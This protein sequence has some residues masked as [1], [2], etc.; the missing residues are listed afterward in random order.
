[1]SKATVCKATAAM[2]LAMSHEELTALRT[3]YQA[4]TPGIWFAELHFHRP[5][6]SVT[7]S[8]LRS[9]LMRADEHQLCHEH[10]G[11]ALGNALFVARAHLMMPFLLECV[12]VAES[13]ARGDECAEILQTRAARLF[14]AEP[15]QGFDSV[16]RQEQV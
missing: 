13:L 14:Q 5:I 15:A 10:G 3:A 4:S 12:A 9:V 16:P 7:A 1:M 8:G 6:V 11:S 2:N